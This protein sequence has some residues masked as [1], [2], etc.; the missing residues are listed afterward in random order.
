MGE[1]LPICCRPTTIAGRYL[2]SV[3]NISYEYW[4]VYRF[5]ICAGGMGI[6][7][8]AEPNRCKSRY[9]RAAVRG[10]I[11]IG[12]LNWNVAIKLK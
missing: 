7:G 8:S 6:A 2:V 4:V 12:Q 9:C 3:G 10:S 5:R 11:E 1:G